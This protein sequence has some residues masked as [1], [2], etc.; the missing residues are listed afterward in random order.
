M[1]RNV[2]Y[3]LRKVLRKGCVIDRK[4]NKNKDTFAWNG[5]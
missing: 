5:N 3:L 4:I 1:W 2:R